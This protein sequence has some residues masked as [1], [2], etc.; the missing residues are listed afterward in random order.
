MDLNDWV[1]HIMEFLRVIHVFVLVREN[2][3]SDG[4]KRKGYLINMK[5]TD[6]F[7]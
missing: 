3:L 2:H 6:K 7:S 1:H 4:H 5:I